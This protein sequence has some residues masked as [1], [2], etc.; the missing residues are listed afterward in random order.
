MGL[1]VDDGYHLWYWPVAATTCSDPGQYTNEG[2]V[3]FGCVDLV[4]WVDTWSVSVPTLRFLNRSGQKR[5][6]YGP[7]RANTTTASIPARS[8]VFC[9][10][11]V[12]CGSHW[13]PSA[14]SVSVQPRQHLYFRFF[15]VARLD[16]W[17]VMVLDWGWLLPRC[18]Y[19]RR[20]DTE[21]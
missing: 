15:W 19:F 1:I 18:P 9:D 7:K 6:H 2:I 4:P 13:F 3:T 10:C 14:A 5:R 8:S 21:T 16:R 20:G 17:L 12:V 11:A